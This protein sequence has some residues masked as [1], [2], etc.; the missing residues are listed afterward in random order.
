M[1]TKPAGRAVMQ[2][3]SK[4]RPDAPQRGGLQGRLPAVAGRRPGA[5]VAGRQPPQAAA[6]RHRRQKSV[7]TSS[8]N[9]EGR[10]YSQVNSMA[11]VFDDAFY[12]YGLDYFER[13]KAQSWTVGGV[14]WSD[15][16]KS[17][18]GPPPAMVYPRQGDLRRQ[19]PQG[20]ALR[21]GHE[22][23]RHHDRGHPAL[24]RPRPDRPA[25]QGGLQDADR[26]HPR[27]DRELA[28]GAVQAPRRS[29]RGHRQQRGPHDHHPRQGLRDPRQDR[30]ARS[31]TSS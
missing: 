4:R 23:R 10:Q 8:S 24:R 12:A 16:Q 1:T 25:G 30:A 20:G 7:I 22:H 26:H 28:A 6:R 5:A 17:F 19:H 2:R 3:R 27:P 14:T 15:K 29:H 31:A 11:R 13:L 9:F 21:Q 18:R